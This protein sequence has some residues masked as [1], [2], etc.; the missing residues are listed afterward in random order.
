MAGKAGP[1]A[2]LRAVLRSRLDFRLAGRKRLSSGQNFAKKIKENPFGAIG[3]VLEGVGRPI[4]YLILHT[5]YFILRLFIFVGR[6]G[7]AFGPALEIA[8]RRLSLSVRQAGKVL[9]LATRRLRRQTSR[10]ARRARKLLRRPIRRVK[11][12]YPPPRPPR[13]TL[14]SLLGLGF[15]VL[16]ISGATAFYF[17]ILADLPSPDQLT[18]RPQPLTTRIYDRN[19][20]LLFK[21]FRGEN[22]TPVTLA[23]VP[24]HLQQ[25]T[26]AIEDSDFYLHR[27]VSPRGITRALLKTSL[28][29][30]LEGGSTITQ[31]LV[32]NALLSPERTLE[33]KLKEVVL[34]FRV[35]NRFS[36][37]EILKMYLN[38]V[39]Y[40]G[41]AYGVEEASQAYF[42]KSVSRLT[43]AESAFLAGLPAAPTSFSP[44]GAHPELARERQIEVLRRMVEEDYITPEQAEKARGE[45]LVLVP[46]RIDISAPHFVMYVKELLV[47]KYGERLVEEGGLE[48]ITSLDLEIQKNAQEIVATEVA[49]LAR[50]NV[51]NGAALV[52]SPATGEILAMV[53]SRDYFDV[54]H[55]GNVNVTTRPRQPGSAIKVVN[56]SVA[57]ENGYTPATI[58]ADTPIT[59]NLPGSP[60]YS[61]VNYDNRF[62]GHISLRV[63]L[64]SSYNVP[65]VK[66]L[67]SYGVPK[68]IEM[69]QKLGITTWDDPSRFG[70]SLTLGGGEVKM[71]D[72]AVVYG[73]LANQGL[74]VDLQPIL[75]VTDS[76]GK[77][78]EQL[79]CDGVLTQEKGFL[80]GIF[81]AFAAAKVCNGQAVLNPLIAYLLT[82]ILADNRARTPAFGSR[83]LLV[84]PDYDVA[85]KT[86][87]S[88][89]LRDNWAFG[90]TPSFMVATWVGNNDNTPMS[91]VA[92]GITGAT[93]I[94]HKI[95]RALLEGKE[96][97]GFA[98]PEDLVAVQ[99]CTLTGELACAGCPSKTEFFLPGT[100]PKNAC[101]FEKIIKE[102]EEREP[103]LK[104]LPQEEKIR[105][106]RDRL[107]G[108]KPPQP[109]R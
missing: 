17:A 12:I 50:L 74:R 84:I 106:L 19:Q 8:G 47:E 86:G 63:A 91:Y 16:L 105:R 33:R 75:R 73:A 41:A 85:V 82:D 13:L 25:A 49:G 60:P 101:Q 29:G 108:N 93:P 81:S 23:Q 18:T 7:R 20:R 76:Q 55:D 4:L 99:I 98:R 79:E 90:F 35:E 100:E 27:G 37:D 1:A 3:L 46:Q 66:V 44:Y 58:L 36:K 39:G 9:P 43:L 104:K 56:Y 54:T 69:G 70:L 2:K 92:S 102:E 57:L 26:I 24:L 109:E 48:V 72:M 34:A 83:S 61:P 40:G 30:R 45:K 62:H 38:E 89:N 103:E 78:L 5:L 22:R 68:M 51:G 67:A 31:Q 52:T 88:N 107:R 71:T 10:F 77:V 53:G 6:G 15:L 64:G 97:E 87:T 11:I 14:K 65:A 59:F 32:K 28:T 21:F 95:M 94:W 96:N 80:S 42:G